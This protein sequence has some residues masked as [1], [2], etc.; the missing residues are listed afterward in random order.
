MTPR[1]PQE[2]SRTFCCSFEVV[3]NTPVNSSHLL[4]S[5]SSPVL[6]PK[7]PSIR[8]SSAMDLDAAN[9][10]LSYDQDA[11]NLHNPDIAEPG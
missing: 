1:D 3:L 5:H 6:Q 2:T 7:R 4:L 10:A 8:N 11:G 9:L